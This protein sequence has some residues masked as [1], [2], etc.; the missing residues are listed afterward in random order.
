MRLTAATAGLAAGSTGVVVG[1][2]A[3]TLE[4]VVRFWDGGPLRVPSELLEAVEER[5]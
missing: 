5:A 1:W 2:Y 4:A 3:N